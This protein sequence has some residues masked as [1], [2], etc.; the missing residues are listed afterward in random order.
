MNAITMHPHHTVTGRPTAS[1]RCSNQHCRSAAVCHTKLVT[2]HCRLHLQ[3]SRAAQLQHIAQ[4]ASQNFAGGY[5]EP[6]QPDSGESA[7]STSG[8]DA[9]QQQT[10]GNK[11]LT[12]RTLLLAGLAI[13]AAAIIHSAGGVSGLQARV[14]VGIG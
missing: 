13:G 5:P 2:A 7:A 6:S 11:G 8:R 1:S 9:S 14:Q 10:G 4:A 3:S 12:S